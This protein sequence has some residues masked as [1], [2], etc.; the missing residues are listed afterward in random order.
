MARQWRGDFTSYPYDYD[1]ANN[2]CDYEQPNCSVDE[3]KGFAKAAMEYNE[4]L[5]SA[6]VHSGPKTPT[7]SPMSEGNRNSGPRNFSIPRSPTNQRKN[8]NWQVDALVGNGIRQLMITEV[9]RLPSSLGYR[10]VKSC[11]NKMLQFLTFTIPSTFIKFFIWDRVGKVF[12]ML[13]SKVK[14]P[15]SLAVLAALNA[16][17][18]VASKTEPKS[19]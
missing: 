9:N 11:L 12:Q 2:T 10:D 13:E 1:Y 7:E 14:D 5:S 19:T 4:H 15:E 3:I 6:A 18:N 16:T 17:V 8:N